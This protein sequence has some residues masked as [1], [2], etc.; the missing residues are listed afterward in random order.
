MRVA[1]MSS[2]SAWQSASVGGCTLDDASKSQDVLPYYVY[3]VRS[4]YSV[5]A[6]KCD[7]RLTCTSGNISNMMQDE[8]HRELVTDGA[9]V[10]AHDLIR[11]MLRV[12]SNAQRVQ[13]A[14]LLLDRLRN[15]KR[16][17]DDDVN[18]LLRL[19]ANYVAPTRELTE[20]ALSLLFFC[21]HR[22]LVIH[23]L[24]KVCSSRYCLTVLV[25]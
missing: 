18:A 22:V 6:I 12:E 23:H 8:Q 17:S 16:D 15:N 4:K 19:V 25:T 7:H 21:D 20:D 1:A 2:S 11:R 10:D 5:V 13:A 24:S 3:K 14:H 9:F